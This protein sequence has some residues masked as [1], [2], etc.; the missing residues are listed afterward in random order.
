ME[1][2]GCKRCNRRQIGRPSKPQKQAKSV[3][4]GCCHRLP[5]EVHGKGRVDATS[6]LLKRGRLPGF[7]KKSWSRDRWC[8]GFDT[9]VSRQRARLHVG[10]SRLD[11]C[12]RQREALVRASPAVAPVRR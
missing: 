6:L 10:K 9:D 12:V 8:A 4:I 11:E 7:A 1:P 2:R 5:Q 3:A